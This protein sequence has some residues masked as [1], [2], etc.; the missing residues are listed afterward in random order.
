MLFLRAR[1]FEQK[2]DTLLTDFKRAEQLYQQALARDPAF[3]LAHAR[4]GQTRANIYHFYEPTDSVR[5]EARAEAETALQLDPNL[6][7]AH[8]AL[9]LCYYWCDRDYEK[10]LQEFRTA[11]SF[12][13]S[14]SEP[15]FLIAAIRRRQGHWQEALDGYNRVAALDPQNPNIFRNIEY[16]NTAL[17]DW[18]AAARAAEGLRAVARDAVDVLI[19]AA[20]IDLWWRGTTATLATT[21]QALPGGNDPDGVVTCGRWERAM[22][23]RDFVAADRALQECSL[24]EISYLNGGLTPKSYCVGLTALARGDETTARA[25]LEAARPKFEAAMAEAPTNAQRHANLG[26]LYAFLGRKDD[27]IREGRRAV[28]LNPESADAVDGALMSANL[29]LIYARSGAADQALPLIERLLRTPGPVDGADYSITRND[30]RLRWEWDPL[31]GDPRF[32]AVVDNP[33]PETR[34]D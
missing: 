7:E 28:E 22:I 1:Q 29:A 9:G 20:Y 11:Q 8:H 27:A 16:T 34:R 19:Q 21:L 5:R 32:K 24:D 26:L 15:G 2:P 6:S 31:R 4:L 30:L 10:A 13:P 14:A 18:P 25:Q 17:R 12:A 23:D 3:A 33:E